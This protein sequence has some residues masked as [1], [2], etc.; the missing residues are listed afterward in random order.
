M[1]LRRNNQLILRLPWPLVTLD[2]EASALDPCSYPIEVGICLWRKPS[3]MMETW[4]TLIEPHPS[5]TAYGLWSDESEKI[6]GISFA[7]LVDEGRTPSET[8]MILNDLAGGQA[9]YCDG[10]RFDEDWARK[11]CAVSDIRPTFKLG[12]WNIL[13][14]RLTSD[15]LA[16]AVQWMEQTHT[17]HRA[18]PDAER[19]ML[20]LA[21]G[22]GIRR[23][24]HASAHKQV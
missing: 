5:W 9:C 16:S 17:P 2:F 10:G 3:S 6:H 1:N 11:L 22:L 12:H 14:N 8:V 13:M 24:S 18:G 21:V 20:A 19:L 7:E 15:G 23:P 4:S